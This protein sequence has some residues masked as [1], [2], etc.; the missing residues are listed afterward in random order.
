M[1]AGWAPETSEGP[2]G[3][4]PRGAKCGDEEGLLVFD[5][6]ER[7]LAVLSCLEAEF[8]EDRGKWFLEAGFGPL[9]DGSRLFE[10]REEA[11]EW[12]ERRMRPTA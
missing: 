6:E 12:I 11:L 5:G 1:L 10:T 4:T 3:G 2:V 7:L 8:Y 9:S